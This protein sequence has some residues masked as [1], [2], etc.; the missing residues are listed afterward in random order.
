G[1]FSKTVNAAGAQ[2]VIY[3]PATTQT[4]SSGASTR[5]PFPGNVIPTNRQNVVGK[6]LVN[7]YPQPTNSRLSANFNGSGAQVNRDDTYDI[8]LDHY[9][10]SSHKVFGRFSKQEPYTGNANFFNNFANSEAPPLVQHRKHGT[11]QDVWTLSPTSIVNLSYGI[12]RQYGE[13]RAHSY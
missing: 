13:R 12:S 2:I 1:D 9:I 4:N 7:F 3:D 8:R 5:S 11:V 6:N 10:G